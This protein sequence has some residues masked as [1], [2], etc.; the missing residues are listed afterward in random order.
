MNLRFIKEFPSPYG[1]SFILTKMRDTLIG[2]LLTDFR[3]LTE[4]YS[5][6]LMDIKTLWY[7]LSISSFRLLMEYHSFLPKFCFPLVLKK[8]YFVSVSLRSYIH[9]YLVKK[10]LNEAESFNE[11]PSPYGVS[12]ILMLNIKFI[13]RY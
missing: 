3:L 7:V 13:W 1:V 8:K 6:L 9:S 4:L 10:I 12:F 5:F 11:F 2:L